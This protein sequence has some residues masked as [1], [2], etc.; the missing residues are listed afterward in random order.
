M[1]GNVN[2][3]L[4]AITMGA[5]NGGTNWPGGGYDPETHTVYAMA[6]TATIAAESVSPPPAGFSDIPYQAGVVGQEFRERL[7]AGT[8][9]YADASRS[10]AAA[11]P[12]PRRQPGTRRTEQAAPTRPARRRGRAARARPARGRAAGG[13]GGGGGGEGA[14]LNVQ[15][16]SILKPP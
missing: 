13:G 8:G 1:V 12:G 15:G 7:A 5:A 2:G 9:T 3:L 11:E 16:L 6:A 10:A 14:G 4:G